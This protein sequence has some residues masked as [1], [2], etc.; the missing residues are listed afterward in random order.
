MDDVYVLKLHKFLY[1]YKYPSENN[2]KKA[3][4]EN[5]KELDNLA[6]QKLKPLLLLI[7]IGMDVLFF[8][9]DTPEMIA[10]NIKVGSKNSTEKTIINGDCLFAP[11]NIYSKNL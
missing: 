2:I 5:M 7:A 11:K 4:K 8:P 6:S 1:P 3:H 10:N 9:D